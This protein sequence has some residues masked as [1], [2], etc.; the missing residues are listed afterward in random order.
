ME[1]ESSVNPFQPPASA[2]VPPEAGSRSTLAAPEFDRLATL[3]TQ[4]L[5]WVR[6]ATLV[7]FLIGVPYLV[8]AILELV[9][10]LQ[11][12]DL[13]PAEMG[14][15]FGQAIVH[16]LIVLFL[17]FTGGYLWRYASAIARFATSRQLATL[18]EAINAQ[19]RFWKSVGIAIG[20]GIGLTLLAVTSVWG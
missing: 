4:T 13:A 3:L 20:I 5:P 6:A 19:R 11:T 18:E 15:A 8:M 1:P 10:L 17:L 9:T 16:W 12:V 7:S 14:E 2:D